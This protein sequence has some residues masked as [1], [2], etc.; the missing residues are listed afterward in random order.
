M[1]RLLTLICFALLAPAAG[2]HDRDPSPFRKREIVDRLDVRD[3]DGVS[4]F[5]CPI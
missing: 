3:R 4:P 2:A 1:R 5:A